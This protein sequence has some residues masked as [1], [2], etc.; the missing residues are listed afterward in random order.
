MNYCFHNKVN[1]KPEAETDTNQESFQETLIKRG[2]RRWESNQKLI[3]SNVNMTASS[4]YW[5]AL[6]VSSWLAENWS[7]TTVI[8]FFLEVTTYESALY[9]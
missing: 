3:L 1:D 4:V 5:V 6:H 9:F 7:A 8:T 2:W